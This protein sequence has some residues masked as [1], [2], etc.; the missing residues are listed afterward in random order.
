MSDEEE[1]RPLLW[2]FYIFLLVMVFLIISSYVK[3]AADDNLHKQKVLA[4]NLAL[5]HDS[6]LIEENSYAEYSIEENFNIKFDTSDK[7][8]FSVKH[9]ESKVPSSFECKITKYDPGSLIEFNS[10]SRV[11]F[12]KTGDDFRVKFI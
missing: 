8:V 1:H 11:M 5:L 12:N 3:E 6:I 2:A 4:I 10:P 7:C 9:E